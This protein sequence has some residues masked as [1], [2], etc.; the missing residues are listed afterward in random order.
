MQ[1]SVSTFS[2]RMTEFIVVFIGIPLCLWL[3]KGYFAP[4]LLPILSCLGVGCAWLLYI[5]GKLAKQWRRAKNI[6]WPQLKPVILTF[7]LFALFISLYVWL[8]SE[9]LSLNTPLLLS[10]GWLLILVLYPLF[11]VIPQEI[12]YR[13]F[14]FHRYKLLFPSKK[15]RVLV[16]SLSFGFGHVIYGSLLVVL[17][18]IIAGFLFSYRYFSS[19]N[20]A[21]V[22][23]EHSLWGLF[24]FAFN[25]GALFSLSQS[26]I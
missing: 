16:S 4:Y 21:I 5:D 12:I 20:T 10:S 13:T 8:V 18:S 11:S 1:L 15:V 14:L 19:G 17:L 25:I 23:I 24:L 2:L 7:L 3:T 9:Q 26:V 22:I 6:N